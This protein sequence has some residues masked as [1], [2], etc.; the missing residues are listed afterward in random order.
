M[1][2]EVYDIYIN[3]IMALTRS[4]VIKFTA[5]A[6]AVNLGVVDRGYSVS[7]SKPSTW[8][9]YLN[10]AG[11]YHESD[12][13]MHVKSFDTLE[14]IEFTKA[15][16]KEHLGTAKAYRWGTDDYEQLLRQYPDQVDLINGIIQPIDFESAYA[17]RNGKILKYETSYVESQEDDL[18]LEVQ[19]WIYNF[20]DRWYNAEYA[21]V[22]DQYL[23]AFFAIFYGLLSKTIGVFRF[24]NCKTE[25]AHS[26]HIREYLKSHGDLGDFFPYLNLEQKLWLYRNID[27]LRLN[28][29]KKET[30][31]L[32][33]EHLLTARNIPLTSYSIMQDYS[34]MPNEIYPSIKFRK[35]PVNFSSSDTTTTITVSEML[36]KERGLALKNE[37]LEYQYQ[38]EIPELMQS[39]KYSELPTKV[40]ESEAVDMSSSDIKLFHETLMSQWL[41]QSCN[42]KYRAYIRI[43]NPINGELMTLSVRDA[44]ILMWY[45]W[46]KARGVELEYIPTLEAMDVVR[47][48]LPTLTELRS[49]TAPFYIH[50]EHIRTLHGLINPTGQYISTE[51]FYDACAQVHSDY[52]DSWRWVSSFEHLRRFAILS[53][54]RMMHYKNV[55]CKLVE[56][57]TDYATWIQR[58]GISLEGLSTLDYERLAADLFSYGTGSNLH[59]KITFSDIQTTMLKLTAK[60]SSYSIQF[61]KTISFSNFTF[62][63]FPHPRLSDVSCST[64]NQY[65]RLQQPSATILRS[66]L[67]NGYRLNMTDGFHSTQ[68]R[69]NV[70][71]HDQEVKKVDIRMGFKPSLPHIGKLRCNVNGVNVLRAGVVVTNG[72]IDRP[73]LPGFKEGDQPVTPT[74]ISSGP[75][76]NA[77][78][79]G[80]LTRGYFGQVTSNELFDGL[81]LSNALQF[82]QGDLTDGGELTWFK[83]AI[84]ERIVFCPSYNL[85]SD[86]KMSQLISAQLDRNQRSVSVNG[87][88]FTLGLPAL[89]PAHN[90]DVT[91]EHTRQGVIRKTGVVEIPDSGLIQSQF[92][93]TMLSLLAEFESQYAVF[94][95]EMLTD[96]LKLKDIGLSYSQT[97]AQCFYGQG[98]IRREE[99]WDAG[100]NGDDSVQQGHLYYGPQGSSDPTDTTFLHFTKDDLALG[101]RPVLTLVQ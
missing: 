65:A 41:Y 79:V 33:I 84:N 4:M 54:M 9:Y 18:M 52:I 46:H 95:R 39:S 30:L 26:F 75:G 88:S 80:D 99:L 38:T 82:Y 2:Q 58:E 61:L 45:C 73:V 49:I 17:A 74:A 55:A 44:F 47:D 97:Q 14:T 69:L 59:R 3:D 71:Y 94:P 67:K 16:L 86:V 5:V 76:P 60:L 24:N 10:L 96:E 77:L 13:M 28:V 72:T 62:I 32:L 23:P 29:G 83:F 25:K 85:R 53:S 11:E 91:V 20:I 34:K 7:R 57:K 100:L 15:N 78:V 48:P 66:K 36:E 37:D 21:V 1:S 70:R 12:T 93:D 31:S 101:W 19:R 56:T 90:S 87:F 27:Y 92:N 22:N 8:K 89:L 81:R 50:D 64:A 51:A 43:H 35:T 6:D 98:S 40:F 63:G 42:G 68:L